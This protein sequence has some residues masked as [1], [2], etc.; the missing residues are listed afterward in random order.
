MP[1][2]VVTAELLAGDSGAVGVGKCRAP[3]GEAVGDEIAVPF[4]FVRCD[5]RWAALAEAQEDDG[6]ARRRDEI[7]GGEAMGDGE[8][9]PGLDEQRGEGR[10]W[11]AKETLGSFALHD[12]VRVLGRLS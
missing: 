4:G 2:L 3:G 11:L 8:L 6:D 1:M 12:E 7:G 10:A 9:E 5:E